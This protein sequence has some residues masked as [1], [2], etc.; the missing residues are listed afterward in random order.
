MSNRMEETVDTII[1]LRDVRKA[2]EMGE[3]TVEAL[4]GVDLELERG[5]YYSIVGPSGSGKSSLLHIVGCMDAPTSGEVRVNGKDVSRLSEKALTRIRAQD[6]GFVFQAFHLNPIL[7]ARENV[8]IALRF[9]GV[10]K[11]VA[12]EKA[13]YWLDKVGLSHRLRHYPAELS[14]GERQRVAIARAIVKDPALILADE[15]TGNLDTRRGQEIVELLRETSREQKTTV[16][17]VTHDMAVAQM[18]D[19]I[20]TL[21][22]GRI[23][24]CQRTRG[25]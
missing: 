14:G 21:R 12:L 17:Q 15:P 24:G 8:A 19:A 16:I 20:L 22:D 18:G 5:G 23:T 2:Y 7:T 11:K 6:I 4:R 9:L 13:E 1:S 10:R 3:T 25:D